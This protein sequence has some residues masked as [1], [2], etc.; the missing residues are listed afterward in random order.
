MAKLTERE[1]KAL[2]DTFVQVAVECMEEIHAPAAMML[3]RLLTYSLAQACV[4]DGSAKTAENLRIMA[5]KVEGGIFDAVG[6]AGADR[7]AKH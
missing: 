3:D 2:C 4:I 7:S 5:E 1:M 6:R